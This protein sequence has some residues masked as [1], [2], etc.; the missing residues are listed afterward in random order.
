MGGMKA[1]ADDIVSTI[2][3]ARRVLCIVLARG[4]KKRR[5]ISKKSKKKLRLDINRT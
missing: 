4:R 1:A 5:D 2:A 3:I